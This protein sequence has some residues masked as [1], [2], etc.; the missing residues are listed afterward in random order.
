L[1]V[2]GE[3][4]ELGKWKEAIFK[5]KRESDDYWVPEKP[6]VTNRYFFCYKYAV[7]QADGSDFFY[8]IGIDRIVDAEIL[9]EQANRNPRSFYEVG[10][11]YTMQSQPIRDK[12]KK[13]ILNDLYQKFRIFF[14]VNYSTN[15][16]TTQL[17]LQENS[18]EIMD[19]SPL[20]QEREASSEWMYTKFGKP[21][22]PYVCN[23]ILDN[24]ANNS[25]GVFVK[26]AET[27]L[28]YRYGRRDVHTPEHIHWER[29]PLRWVDVQEPHRYRGQLGQRGVPWF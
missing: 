12:L 21:V 22:R 7:L 5:M 11:E 26:N 10:S 29:E 13:V 3:L 20:I 14:A 6:L 1:C 19:N 8:E 18:K 23:V 9:P 17:V 4:P 16:G 2:L 25:D 15:D 24:Y 27:M 28:K